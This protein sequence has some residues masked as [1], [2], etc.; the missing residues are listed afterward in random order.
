MALLA[1]FLSKCND[2]KFCL[3]CFLNF[4]SDKILKQ[5]TQ[6]QWESMPENF[7]SVYNKDNKHTNKYG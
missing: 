6:L 4:Q 3:S 5:T 2:D 1:N 7:K